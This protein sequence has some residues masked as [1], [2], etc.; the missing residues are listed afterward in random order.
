MPN[1]TPTGFQWDVPGVAISNYV[2]DVNQGTVYT[3]FPKSGTNVSFYWVD[4]ANRAVTCTASVGWK[5]NRG[6]GYV[7]RGETLEFG[8]DDN[9][10][11][12]APGRYQN[13]PV[14]G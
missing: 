9:D 14:W 11:H 5:V 3:N 4:G 6:S 10:K 1:L 2:A 12:D 7:Q 13:G 8:N